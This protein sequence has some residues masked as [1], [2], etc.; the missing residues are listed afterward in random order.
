[1]AT[2][3]AR[4]AAPRVAGPGLASSDPLLDCA[5]PL[6]GAHV[7]I[8]GRDFSD[9]LC[10]LIHRGAA[11]VTCLRRDDHSSAVAEADVVILHGC[12]GDQKLR[13]ALAFARRVLNSGGRVVL[14]GGGQGDAPMLARLLAEHGFFSVRC[15]ALPSG[16]VL[17][18]DLP[19]F[20]PLRRH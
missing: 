17:T 7:L 19:F 15:R 12:A 18:A 1:M 2:L 14:R 8:L 10:G 20:G 3:Q 16:A 9:M 5:E 11:A 6:A 4:A 13:E